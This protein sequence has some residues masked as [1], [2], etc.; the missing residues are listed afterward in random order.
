[1]SALLSMGGVEKRYRVGPDRPIRELLGRATRATRNALA[2]S[3]RV[4]PRS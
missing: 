4:R 1:M 3:D 2:T